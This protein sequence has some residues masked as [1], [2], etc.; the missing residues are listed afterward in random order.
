MNQGWTNWDKSDCLF[1]ELWRTLYVA[2]KAWHR[3]SITGLIR[4]IGYPRQSAH[5]G[6]SLNKVGCSYH[7]EQ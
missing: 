2:E 7:Q 1:L 3:L 6:K 4:R 5:F